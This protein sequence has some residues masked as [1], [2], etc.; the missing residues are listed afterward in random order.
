MWSKRI[1]TLLPSREGLTTL[2]WQVSWLVKDYNNPQSSRPAF[3]GTV[4]ATDFFT[5]SCGAA[6]DFSAIEYRSTEFPFHPVV[7]DTKVL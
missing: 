4:T 2:S 5:Y 7:R 1:L 3:G 6:S